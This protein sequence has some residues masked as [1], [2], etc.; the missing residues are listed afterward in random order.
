[1]DPTELASRRPVDA[2]ALFWL[3]F[4]LF[5]T[6][7]ISALGALVP[8]CCILIYGGAITGR[9]ELVEGTREYELVQVIQRNPG[10]RLTL[11]GFNLVLWVSVLIG[12]T[13]LLRLREW[14]RVFIK[15]LITIDLFVTL[16]VALW[17]VIVQWIYKRPV[18]SE[19][20]VDVVI[21]VVEVFIVLVL[22]H[23]R[24]MSLTGVHGRPRGEA[25]RAT[26]VRK[27][28]SDRTE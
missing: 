10:P 24:V 15:V 17:P 19:V 26:D 8:F 13:Y 18:R 7:F 27:P 3:R 1:M 21:T 14:A 5:V 9:F 11:E 28:W 25:R 23:P 6:L 20:T 22:S 12:A 16:G 4:A 2:V